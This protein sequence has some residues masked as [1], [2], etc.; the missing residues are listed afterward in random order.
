M[1]VPKVFSRVTKHKPPRY[2]LYQPGFNKS[3][4]CWLQGSW[5]TLSKAEWEKRK[6]KHER[7][8]KGVF[9]N[10][11]H[12]RDKGTAVKNMTS[13][14]RQAW[15]HYAGTALLEGI[16]EEG[17]VLSFDVDLH[18]DRVAPSGVELLRKHKVKI[19]RYVKM[20]RRTV[21]QLRGQ[22]LPD[23]LVLKNTKAEAIDVFGKVVNQNLA[24]SEELFRHSLEFAGDESNPEPMRGMAVM[25]AMGVLMSQEELIIQGEWHAQK[26]KPLPHHDDEQEKARYVRMRAFLEKCEGWE[27]VYKQSKES[28]N[29]CARTNLDNSKGV[30]YSF[31]LPEFHSD[32]T[33]EPW[34]PK[35]VPW[36]DRQVQ[37]PYLSEEVWTRW[38]PPQT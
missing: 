28:H 8:Y 9:A 20:G 10:N 24:S 6:A 21:D 7:D 3:N 25:T 34:G 15:E 30:I 17:Q 11:G 29:S 16:D 32:G 38:E 2:Q 19:P 35:D 27:E 18:G 31:V 1:A 4:S 33:H 23:D 12:Y 22:K 14:Q 37:A 26:G 36:G 5:V 13:R